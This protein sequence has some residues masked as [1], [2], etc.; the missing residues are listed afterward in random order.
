MFFPSNH[1]LMFTV[2]IYLLHK[3]LV[4]VNQQHKEFNMDHSGPSH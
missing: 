2:F 3:Q 4:M 1:M